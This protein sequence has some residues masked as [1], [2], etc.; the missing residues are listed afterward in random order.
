M[1]SLLSMLGSLASSR[2]SS[3]SSCSPCKP[4]PAHMSRS[5]CP[6]VVALFFHVSCGCAADSA[7][8]SVWIGSLTLDTPQIRSSLRRTRQ[9]ISS[10]GARTTATPTRLRWSF[11]LFLSLGGPSQGVP[12]CT[13]DS[14]AAAIAASTPL[15][16]RPTS[17]LASSPRSSA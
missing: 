10:L 6:A 7:P 15:R 17:S 16:S 4:Q 9:K 11:C 12:S 8:S 3:P 2:P 5:D 13:L 14:Q 1:T